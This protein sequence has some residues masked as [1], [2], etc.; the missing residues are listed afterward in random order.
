MM[1]RMSP[2]GSVV[3]TRLGFYDIAVAVRIDPTYNMSWDLKH[4]I[5]RYTVGNSSAKRM[6][7]P[8]NFT[9]R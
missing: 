7:E 2:L 8:V 5:I 4:V 6:V 3:L 1:D 9:A